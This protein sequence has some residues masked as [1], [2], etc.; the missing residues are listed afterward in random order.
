M[1]CHI[2]SYYGACYECHSIG[3]A[4]SVMGLIFGGIGIFGS[5]NKKR[6]IS[7]VLGGKGYD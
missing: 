2:G 4:V 5:F 7:K 1:V 6:S 3:P